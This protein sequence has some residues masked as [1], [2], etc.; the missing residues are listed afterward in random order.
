MTSKLD[1]QSEVVPKFVSNN[2]SN[3]EEKFIIEA[4]NVSINVMT[5]EKKPT[6]L[7]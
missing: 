5:V 7:F 1:V 6:L 4:E 3:F 2:S